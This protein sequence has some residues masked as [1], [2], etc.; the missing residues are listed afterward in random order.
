MLTEYIKGKGYSAFATAVMHKKHQFVVNGIL[1]AAGLYLTLQKFSGFSVAAVLQPYLQPFVTPA[2]LGL[3][4]DVA[5]VFVGL[6]SLSKGLTHIVEFWPPLAT[7]TQEPERISE[8]I[9]NINSE[10]RRHLSDIISDPNAAIATFVRSHNFDVNVAMAVSS[11][12][13]HLRRA[14]SNLKVKPRDIFISVYQAKDMRETD[15]AKVV[16]LYL[17][18]WEP[19]RDAVFTRTLEVGK[20]KFKDY[21]CVKAILK[22]KPSV[23]LTDC[24]SYKKTGNKRGDIKHYIGL[25]L[26]H[27]GAVLGF[28]NIEFHNKVLFH[29]ESAMRDFLEK[30]V[31]AFK[32]LIEYQFLKK[33]FFTVVSE[34]LIKEA[35]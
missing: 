7:A 29:D 28:I 22:G 17:S 8:C 5:F 10:I 6:A 19:K 14:F 4:K 21:E 9:L 26:E 30:E 12:A 11:L 33:N 35:V 24:K 15:P 3:V 27:A 31:L 2:F 25:Q 1:L 32:Y 16:L 34:N 23:V 20:P 13:D 18:H